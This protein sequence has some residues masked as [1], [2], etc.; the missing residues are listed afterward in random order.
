MPLDTWSIVLSLTLSVF[1]FLVFLLGRKKLE[2]V[3]IEK[4]VAPA[5]KEALDVLIKNF[6]S[7]G[8][9]PSKSKLI[10]IM[11]SLARKYQIQLLTHMSIHNVLDNLIYYVISNDL[12]DPYKKK[13]ISDN[14]IRLKQEPIS[15]ED[16]LQMLAENEEAHSWKQKLAYSQLAQILIG[17]SAFIIVLGITITQFRNYLNN[18]VFYL[19]NWFLVSAI[20][21]SV[22]VAFQSLITILAHQSLITILAQQNNTKNNLSKET[23]SNNSSI[24]L[25]NS[26][27]LN[28]N[29]NTTITNNQIAE[30]NNQ[31]AEN[32]NQKLRRN[33]VNQPL[34]TH[35]NGINPNSSSMMELEIDSLETL[36][37]TQTP[38]NNKKASTNSFNA[39]IE[40]NVPNSVFESI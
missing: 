36:N 12:L 18:Q 10:S 37:N 35:K 8:D 33:S 22:L 6:L 38:V 5:S 31:I 3:L 40:D 16:Y 29:S 34:I 11:T 17:S 21:F 30:T 24:P 28:N 13:E 23:I 9:I 20:G 26:G 4:K 1:A 19:M 7:F 25:L 14:L 27:N 32:N 15:S 2:L 39:P